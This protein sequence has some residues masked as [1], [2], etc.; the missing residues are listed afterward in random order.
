MDPSIDFDALFGEFS[1]NTLNFWNGRAGRLR[2]AGWLAS[3]KDPEQSSA[4]ERL[5]EA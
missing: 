2:G 5:V 3:R 1:H 4:G